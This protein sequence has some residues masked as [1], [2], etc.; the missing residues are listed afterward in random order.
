MVQEAKPQCRGLW[1]LPAG[2]VEPHENLGAAVRREVREETGL[3]CEPLTL[4]ALEE[5]GPMWVRFV[6]L[7]RH[8]GECWGGWGGIGGGWGCR[9][10]AQRWDGG[11]SPLLALSGGNCVG[12]VCALQPY[13][14]VSI[15]YGP[16]MEYPSLTVLQWGVHSLWPCNGVS[17][18]YS[19]TMG[20]P[21]LM[22]LPHSTAP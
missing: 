2:R 7:A 17:I 18:P 5:R 20:C 10:G 21:F 4:L 19:P 3:Q 9:W 8:T 6:F 14:G 13:N 22:A 12:Y 11:R 1:Y 16:T 15:P